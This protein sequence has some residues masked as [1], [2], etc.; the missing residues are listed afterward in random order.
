MRLRKLTS[1][2]NIA[3]AIAANSHDT[4]TQVGCAL[5]GQDGEVILTT[6]NGFIPGAP[7]K[8]LP[9]TRPQKYCYINH[10]ER[11][12]IYQ[13][14]K[15]GI[16]INNCTAVSTLSPCIECCRALWSSGVKTIYFRDKYRDFDENVDMLDLKLELEEVGPYYKLNLSTKK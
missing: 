11:N 9:T 16:S 4:E 5:I 13:A 10:A 1:Y 12:A 6:Y 3:D 14:A 8:K 7:D 15:R 2:F